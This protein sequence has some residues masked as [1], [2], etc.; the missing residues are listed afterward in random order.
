VKPPPFDYQA[1]TSVEEAVA[2]LAEHGEEAKVLAGGQSLVPLL[3]LRLARPSVVVDVNGVSELDALSNGAGLRVGAIVRQRTAE[4]SPV[5]ASGNPLL[6]TA[7]PFIGHPAIRNRGSV[8]GTIAHADPAAELPAVLL[9]L[10]GDVEAV[11]P[12]GSRSVPAAEFFAGFLTTALEPDELLTAVRFPPWP[13]G[14]GWSF[15]EFSRR[16]GDFAVAGVAVVLR[17]D[18][19]GA[20]A[21]ARIALTGVDATPV[22]ASKAEASLVGQVPSTAAWEA[23]GADA[24]AD[25]EPP[26]DLHGTA[27]YRRHLV[28][29]LVQRA[30]VEAHGRVGESR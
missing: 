25:L 19:R 11:G 8:G 14:A 1:P 29:V 10:D 3:A 5:V 27:D 28:K 24:A 6:A 23:A 12:R 21:E 18:G 22:R 30:L 7:I 17:L 4:R 26:S 9:A 13:A 20:V 16:S 15:H 2:L